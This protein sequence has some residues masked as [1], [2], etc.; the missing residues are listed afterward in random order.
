MKKALVLAGGIAQAAL[1]R[2]L[3]DR[4]YYTIL[5][6]MNPN[7]YAVKY[8][9]CF[10]C[11]SA[12]DFDALETLARAENVSMVVTA[13]ADQILLA[14]TYLCEKLGLRTYISCETAKLVSDKKFMKD[15]FVKNGILTSRY[16]VLD[17]YDEA[18]IGKL[19]FPLIVKPA[20]A[21]S[22]RGVN[23]CGDREEVE[24]ALAEAVAVSKTNTAVVEEFIEGTELTVEA[25]VKEGKAVLLCCGSKEKLKNGKFVSYGSL[26]P[27][28]ISGELKDKISETAQQIA[29]AFHLVNSPM[30]IQFITDGK[31]AYVLE[32]CARTGGFIKYEIVKR[33][34]GFD[35][36]KAVVDL[37]EGKI[38]SVGRVAPEKKFL[39][40]CFL[41]CSE[42]TVERYSGF[43]EMHDAGVIDPYWLVREEGYE[44]K[45]IKSNGDRAACY[46]IQD[47][48]YEGLTEKYQRAKENVKILDKD[49]RNLIR[50]DLM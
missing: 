18:E 47:D 42:G 8:A 38:P 20:D 32:F 1:I 48:T 13:C 11:V 39:V 49:G 41:Y 30:L 14:E 45:G 26:Y 50:F 21:Y 31:N 4:G 23:K 7:C 24:R 17:R 37:H 43:R 33:T 40:S 46:L 10:R 12:M 28:N 27:A 35:P 44:F 25:F 15:V 9:D 34:S 19:T 22:S 6:D 29:D 5:C 36:I 2:E 3:K 16:A